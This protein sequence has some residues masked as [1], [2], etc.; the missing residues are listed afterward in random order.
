MGEWMEK[1]EDS[2]EVGNYVDYFKY[3]QYCADDH[4]FN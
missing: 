4:F 3:V 1:P 2:L